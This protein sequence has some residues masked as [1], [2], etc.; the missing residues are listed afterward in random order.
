MLCFI[1][2]EKCLKNTILYLEGEMKKKK[3]HI[4]RIEFIM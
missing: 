2:Y 3:I 4:N 1:I